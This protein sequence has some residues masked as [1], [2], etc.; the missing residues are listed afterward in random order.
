VDLRALLIDALD[1]IDRTAK[2]PPELVRARLEATNF[3]RRPLGG[4]K[5][6]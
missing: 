1:R 2:L 4:G 3:L 6:A 5:K